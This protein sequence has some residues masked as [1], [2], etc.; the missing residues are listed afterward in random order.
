MV[1]QTLHRGISS[2]LPEYRSTGHYVFLTL[3]STFSLLIALVLV[4]VP[5]ASHLNLSP[6]LV[7]LPGPDFYHFSPS[8]TL[9]PELCS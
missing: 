3:P 1:T 2:R 5:R 9:Q 8:P 4:Y 6:E 7:Y